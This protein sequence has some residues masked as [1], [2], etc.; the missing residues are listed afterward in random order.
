MTSNVSITYIFMRLHLSSLIFILCLLLPATAFADNYSSNWKAVEEHLKNQ[1]P[2]SALE[3]VQKIY[4]QARADRNDQQI[5]KSTSY[6]IGLAAQLDENGELILVNEMK[7][8][9]SHSA[10]PLSRALFESLLGEIYWTYYLN[11]NWK[12]SQRTQTEDINKE[13]FRTWDSKTL[14]DTARFHYLA[15]FANT[16]I[17]KTALVKDYSLLLIKNKESELYRPTM[18]DILTYKTIEFLQQSQTLTSQAS[19]ELSDL[20]ALAPMD[21]FIKNTAFATSP[22]SK[23]ALEQGN[24]NYVIIKLFQDLLTFHKSDKLPDALIDADILRLQFA[25]TITSNES[26]DSIYLSSLQMIASKFSSFPISTLALYSIAQEEFNNEHHEKAMEICNNAVKRFPN[27]RGAVNSKAL[28]SQILQKELI[29]TVEKTQVQDMPFISNVS[30]RN[31]SKLYFRIVKTDNTSQVRKR[32][33]GYDYE[34]LEKNQIKSLLDLPNVHKWEQTL[35]AVSDFRSHSVDVKSPA[36]PLGK[37]VLLVSPDEDFSLSNNTISYTPL[38]VTRLSLQNQR[39]KDGSQLFIVNDAQTGEPVSGV[40]AKVYSYVYNNSGETKEKLEMTKETDTQGMFT[41]KPNSVSNNNFRIDLSKGADNYS[42]SSNYNIYASTPEQDHN[43]T[44]FFTDRQLYRPGQTIYFKGIIYKNNNEQGVNQ[45][46]K[47]EKTTVHFYNRNSKEI[48]KLDLRTNEF[49]SFSGSFIAPNTGLTGNMNIRNESGSQSIKIEEYKRP[50]FEV[51]F[52]PVK[53]DI[54]LEKHVT[55]TGTAIGFAGANIAGATVQ[56]RVTR[57]VRYP[58]FRWGIPQQY[59]QNKEIIHGTTETN[60]NGEFTVQFPATPDKSIDR[61]SLPVFTYSISA[62]VTD[63]NGETHSSQT[64]VSAGYVSLEL[65]VS[66]GGKDDKLAQRLFMGNEIGTSNMPDIIGNLKNTIAISS[67]NI[68]DVPIPARGTLLIQELKQPERAEIIRV[69]LLPATDQYLLNKDEFVSA[70]PNESYKNDNNPQSWS[71]ASVVEK[72]EFQTDST[73]TLLTGSDKKLPSGTYRVTVSAIDISGA[74][75]EV[76]SHIIIY[77]SASTKPPARFPVSYIPKTISCQPGQNASFLYGTSFK[78][79]SVLYQMEY[80]G[81]IIEQKQLEFSEELRQFTIPIEEKHRGGF[82]ILLSMVHD[83]RL[84][85]TPINIIVPWSNKDLKIETATFRD[86]LLPGAKEHWRLM[87]KNNDGKAP[88]AEMVARLYDA[89]LDA[90]TPNTWQG[91]A[92]QNFYSDLQV[93]NNS[94]GAVSAT[95]YDDNWNKYLPMKNIEYELLN[96]FTSRTYLNYGNVRFKR[97]MALDQNFRGA[98]TNAPLIQAEALDVD[99]RKAGYFSKSQEQKIADS[100][101]VSGRSIKFDSIKDGKTNNEQISNNE[102]TSNTNKEDLQSVKTRTNFNE[103]AFF[104]PQLLTDTSGSIVLDFTMPEALTKWKMTAFAHTP[105]MQTGEIERTVITQKELM[106]EP[107]MPRFL[108]S[109][110]TITL[111]VKITNLSKANLTGAVELSLL[112]AYTMKSVNTEFGLTNQIRQSFTI[113][114]TSATN[115]SWKIVVPDG[116]QAVVYRIA[117]KSGDFSDGEEAPIPV[118]PNRM[119]VTESIP[120]WITNLS[121]TPVTKTFEFTKLKESTKSPTL[122]NHKLTLEMTS[123]PAWYA[124]QALP[125]LMEFPYECS[126]QIFNRFYANSIASYLVNSK[127]KIKQVFDR[128]K[129][130]QDALTSNLEKNQELK[131]LLLE[132]TPWVMQGQD[133]SERKKRVALLFDLNRMTDELARTLDKLSKMQQPS[134]GFAWFGG[135]T[136]SSF[137]TNYILAGFGHLNVMGVKNDNRTIQNI[138]T[139]ALQYSD[140]MMNEEYVRLKSQKNFSKKDDNLDYSTIQYLYARSYFLDTKVEQKY[141]EAF[142]YWMEQADAHWQKKGL[143]SQAMIAL[144]LDRF[145]EKSTAKIIIASVKERALQNEELGMYW[146][147]NEAGWMW[148]N[149]P[150]ETQALLIEAFDEVTGDSKSVELMK[151]WLLKQKQVQDWK[152]TKATAEACYALLRRGTDWLETNEQVAITLGGKALVTDNS[153]K[154][155]PEAGTGY[156]KTSWNPNEIFAGMGD[157]SLSKSTKGIAWGGMYW[158]YYEQLDKITPHASPLSLGRKIYKRTTTDNGFELTSI[159]PE[160][161]LKVGDVIV[162][163][164]ELRTDRDMEYI[165]LKDMRGAG[166]EQ[167]TQLSGYKWQD[168]LGYYQSPRDASMNFF[169]GWMPKGVYSLEYPL[170][171]THDG[172]FSSGIST[173]QSMYAP[174][175]SSH[176]GGVILKVGK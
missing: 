78:S 102:Q 126:E 95:P 24:H 43:R 127:P 39:L 89:S 22:E 145:G 62:D 48:A 19:P 46:L 25:R 144:A 97:S 161:P 139:N 15:A 41:I 94:F 107:N 166:F 170:R 42:T 169:I 21:E 65:S 118:L 12:F 84:Y 47:N 72:K 150:I 16:Q 116:Y 140:R 171:V 153:D 6:K 73:G 138:I 142:D 7:D 10:S 152:T 9:I 66:I 141:S 37:Y 112:D 53:G 56:Y 64:S 130:S 157:I 88:L 115:V 2:K 109:G 173:I 49:G 59:G 133:E 124:V 132:E 27:S 83:G 23:K 55:V 174:E 13:D 154:A 54:Q 135:M 60:A 85:T 148:Y 123:N 176:S 69:R 99:D 77:D 74:P 137:I 33:R 165:H 168:G 117:A 100:A 38:F 80:H 149:A 1:R 103:T 58:Y 155:K 4:D 34:Y 17:L 75:V 45:V 82:S 172:T 81:E 108:R 31:L 50:K 156:F 32:M 110:D 151:V 51:S 120:L 79:A 26:K 20:S 91:F 163:K 162:V 3:I 159:S 63:I 30:Y 87:I 29:V 18:F 134:G 143:M 86:K 164:L 128:W 40:T 96:L 125:M 158:Q 5:I 52:K 11:N 106:V 114:Q 8:E 44:L 131:S 160:T 175:F 57:T 119:L 122:R 90:I 68:N 92:W 36:L 104:F 136:E 35:P 14:R 147:G 129:E 113:A 167:L 98:P 146:K 71:V 70:F 76:V 67:H 61:K 105:D 28:Q 93:S 101:V 121:G 111:P